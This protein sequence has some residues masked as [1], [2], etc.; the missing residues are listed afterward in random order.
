MPVVRFLSWYLSFVSIVVLSESGSRWR[1]RV[2]PRPTLA[3]NLNVFPLSRTRAPGS[4]PEPSITSEARN[5]SPTGVAD[6]IV[7]PS[8]QTVPDVVFD[9]SL[10]PL[11]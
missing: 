8:P 5:R 11:P 4:K 7:T 1:I 10:W 3:R 6:R 9:A 2:P